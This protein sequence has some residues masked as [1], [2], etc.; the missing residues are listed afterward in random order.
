MSKVFVQVSAWC[1]IDFERIKAE[2]V[3]GFGETSA[4]GLSSIRGSSNETEADDISSLERD[5]SDNRLRT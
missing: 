4:K 1:Q 5:K 3:P 2:I